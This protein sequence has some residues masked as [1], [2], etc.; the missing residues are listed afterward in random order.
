LA[1][2]LTALLAAGVPASTDP[3]TSA[4]DDDQF[5][6]HLE[7]TPFRDDD[8]REQLDQRRLS[9]L[10]FSVGATLGGGK[11]NVRMLQS[12]M[13]LRESQ[14][15]GTRE[16]T[17]A[18]YVGYDGAVERFRGDVSSLL[19]RPDSLRRLQRSLTDGLEGC[20]RLDAFARLMETYGVSAQDM[21]SILSSRAACDTFRRAA[22]SSQVQGTLARA[23][24]GS[25]QC[26]GQVRA[27]EEEIS[28][29]ERLVEDLRKID[30]GTE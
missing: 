9:K 10:L 22:F 4:M 18:R 30:D 26:R 23:L 11:T 1:V 21:L 6:E 3:D 20:W 8:P 16:M 2:G 24:E 27:L 13:Q 28:E 29:L 5:I 25:E 7:R 17:A 19:D 14:S 15:G 12:G